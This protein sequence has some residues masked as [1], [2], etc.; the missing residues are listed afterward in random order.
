MN[1]SLK[2]VRVHWK[3]MDSDLAFKL[4]QKITTLKSLVVVV[5][6]ST[7]NNVSK[8]ETTLLKYFPS[9]FRTRITEALGFK[10]LEELVKLRGLVNVKVEHVDRSQA[11]RRSEEERSGL[12]Q[13]L[14]HVA[15]KAALGN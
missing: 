8:K 14:R 9:R 6:R 13:Y 3:G 1:Y 10:E 11:H 5:S 15:G 12:A 4:L 2:S 7:T